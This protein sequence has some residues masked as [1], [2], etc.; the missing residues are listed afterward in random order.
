MKPGSYHLMLLGLKHDLKPG[1]T[2]TLTLRFAK[3]GQI[4]LQAPV[5]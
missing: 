5:R 4:S 3:A 1:D 2:V